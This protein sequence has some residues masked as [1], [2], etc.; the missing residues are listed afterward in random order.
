MVARS[1]RRLLL[2]LNCTWRF[3]IPR[4]RS[5]IGIGAVLGAAEASIQN[6]T[7]QT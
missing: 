5:I 2:F 3:D 1:L 6:T 4:R 7:L